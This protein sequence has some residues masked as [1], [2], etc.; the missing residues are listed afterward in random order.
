[1]AGYFSQLQIH[2]NYAENHLQASKFLFY[3][4]NIKYIDQWYNFYTNFCFHFDFIR[5]ISQTG[6]LEGDSMG[7]KKTYQ[8]GLQVALNREPTSFCFDLIRGLVE[9][10]NIIRKP[11]L[12]R[13]LWNRF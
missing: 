6:T 12:L 9:T 7:S 8:P 3:I 11:E 1:M 13:S 2:L 5:D 4:L 10:F